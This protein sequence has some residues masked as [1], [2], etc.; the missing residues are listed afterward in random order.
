[1]GQKFEYFGKAGNRIVSG[2][3]YCSRAEFAN[4]AAHSSLLVRC[5]K[6]EKPDLWVRIATGSSGRTFA[7]G[8]L[9]DE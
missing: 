2:F 8:G 3:V 6:T 5:G 9:D 7:R 1:M 4:D